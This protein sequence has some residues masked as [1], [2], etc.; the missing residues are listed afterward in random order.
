MPTNSSAAHFKAAEPELADLIENGQ[1]TKGMSKK[2]KGG[3]SE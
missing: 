2:G 3:R 1:V